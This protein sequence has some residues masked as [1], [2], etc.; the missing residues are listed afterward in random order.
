[1]VHWVSA[2][3]SSLCVWCSQ[4]TSKDEWEVPRSAFTLAEELGRGAFG[5]VVKGCL[6]VTCLSSVQVERVQRTTGSTDTIIP[7]AIKLLL[8]N[9]IISSSEYI[10]A[11]L[12]F[13]QFVVTIVNIASFKSVDMKAWNYT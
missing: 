7:V 9:L 6:S 3:D 2:S 10:S 1:M 5:H 8:G 11:V 12:F 4:P 13:R